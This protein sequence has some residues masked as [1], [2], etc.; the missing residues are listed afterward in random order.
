MKKAKMKLKDNPFKPN[1]SRV[2]R[3]EARIDVLVERVA[4]LEKDLAYFIMRENGTD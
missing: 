4:K 2:D 3:L 1:T